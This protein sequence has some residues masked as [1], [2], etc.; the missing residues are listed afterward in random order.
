MSKLPDRYVVQPLFPFPVALQR[1]QNSCRVSSVEVK[2]LVACGSRFGPISY[3]KTRWRSQLFRG[4]LISFIVS[5]RT[6]SRR[7]RNGGVTV[8]RNT[9]HLWLTLERYKVLIPLI[10]L[11]LIKIPAGIR[12]PKAPSVADADKTSLKSP[13]MFPRHPFTRLNHI[14]YTSLSP[15]IQHNL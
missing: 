15:N 10:K 3:T 5:T 9:G 1:C 6:I 2:K 8:T 11:L 13:R 7:K 14:S 12:S 4:A